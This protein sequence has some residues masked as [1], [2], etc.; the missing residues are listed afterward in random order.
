[1]RMTTIRLVHD[2][3]DDCVVASFVVSGVVDVDYDSRLLSS[4]VVCV[5]VLVT[6]QICDLR[7]QLIVRQ[8]E[9]TNENNIFA[10]CN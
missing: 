10:G 3:N 9:S 2:G 5:C 8:D 4:T 7:V 6:S 1:M